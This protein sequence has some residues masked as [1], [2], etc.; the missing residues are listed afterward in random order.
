MWE[1]FEVLRRVHAG[2]AYRS[3]ARGTGRSPKTVRRYLRL[4]RKLGWEPKGAVAPDEQLAGRVAARLR[5]G[6][7]ELSTTAAQTLLVPHLDQSRQW[8]AGRS[9]ASQPAAASAR[10][11]ARG[12]R[13]ITSR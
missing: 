1:V 13:S 4:A 3:V 7:R 6:P 8:L 10:A 11:T 12:S 5:P 2:E 9:D